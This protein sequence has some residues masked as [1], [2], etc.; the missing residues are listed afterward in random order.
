MTFACYGHLKNLKTYPWILAALLG[1]GIALFEYI[2][3]LPANLI[4]SSQLIVRQL[5]II[6]EVIT[7]S[8]YIPFCKLY[9]KETLKTNYLW[10][11]LCMNG[12]VY[13]MFKS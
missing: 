12:A 9:L 6:Q 5:K 11:G 10:A 13:F 4:G 8:V 3:Q 2:A 1:W 7:R